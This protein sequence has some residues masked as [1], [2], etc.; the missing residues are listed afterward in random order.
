[1]PAEDGYALIG[2]VRDL[3]SS[4]GKHTPVRQVIERH[5]PAHQFKVL[6]AA[7]QSER[8]I[9]RKLVQGLRP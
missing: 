3:D 1:M 8:T 7:E 4:A 2:K 6:K 9:I 5:L